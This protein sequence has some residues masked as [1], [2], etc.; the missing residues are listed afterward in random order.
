MSSFACAGN[1]CGSLKKHIMEQEKTIRETAVG[2]AGGVPVTL[3]DSLPVLMQSLSKAR[4]K[5]SAAEKSQKEMDHVNKGLRLNGQSRKRL[6]GNGK[7]R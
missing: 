4:E 2:F 6:S 7:S 3:D 1:M 5:K